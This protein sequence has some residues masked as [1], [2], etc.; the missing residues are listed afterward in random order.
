MKLPLVFKTFVL[1]ILE[2]TLK[3]GLIVFCCENSIYTSL[4]NTWP[5]GYKTFFV[6]NST[7]HEIYPAHKC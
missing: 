4:Y 3:I 5:R 7:E 2:W 1:S 6:H